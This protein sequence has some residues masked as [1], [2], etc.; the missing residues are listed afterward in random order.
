VR[1]MKYF[2]VFAAVCACVLAGTLSPK[3]PYCAYS[4][5]SFYTL[6]DDPT[7]LKDVKLY[8]MTKDDVIVGAY[9]MENGEKGIVREDLMSPASTTVPVAYGNPSESPSCLTRSVSIDEA[10]EMLLH[11]AGPLVF[12]FAYKGEPEDDELDGT[13]CEKYCWTSDSSTSCVY[14]KKDCKKGCVVGTS[15]RRNQPKRGYAPFGKRSHPSK[16]DSTEFTHFTNYKELKDMSV[17]TLDKETYPGCYDDSYAYK[18][19]EKICGSSTESAGSVVKSVA[20]VV[21]AAVLAALF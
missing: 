8:V 6:N 15:I 19:P 17:F 2:V 20:V 7:H 9:E 3:Q 10:G 12:Q 18:A 11:Y 5:D 14:V 1:T 16:R 13:K 4:V 21:V